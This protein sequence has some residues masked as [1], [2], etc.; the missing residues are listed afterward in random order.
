MS[1]TERQR[2]VYQGRG[3]LLPECPMAG[4]DKFRR[5]GM[6]P[7]HEHQG[8]EICYLV[9]GAV[10]WRV[11]ETLH[12]VRGGELFI[13]RPREK[14]GGDGAV[15]HPCEVYWFHV[16]LPPKEKWPMLPTRERSALA[17]GFASITRRSFPASPHTQ[18]ACRRLHA[19]HRRSD[20]LA[21]LA[22]RGALLDLLSNVLRDHAAASGRPACSEPIQ[23][24]MHY[25]L[26]HLDEPLRIADVARA[27]NM[28]AG[29]FHVRFVTETGQTP[30]DWRLRQMIARAKTMLSESDRPITQIAL[31]LGCSTSQYFATAFRRITGVSPRTYRST[32]VQER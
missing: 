21:T 23:R 9:S 26:D 2:E 11:G 27:V 5:A 10:D 24:A 31:D 20:A 22:A 32:F 19:E 30:A 16:L 18:D 14:H 15:M 6:L 7:A 25:M 29:R 28:S 3:A 17:R 1:R 13:T 12:E 4:W 8:Y